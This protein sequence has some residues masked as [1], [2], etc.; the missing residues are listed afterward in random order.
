LL[1]F[2]LL[3]ARD[4]LLFRTAALF[5]LLCFY[6]PLA[7]LLSLT[8]LLLPG[9]VSLLNLFASLLSPVSLVLRRLL[10]HRYPFTRLSRHRSRRRPLLFGRL[11]LT[12]PFRLFL[13]FL[14]LLLAVITA[15]AAAPLCL[16]ICTQTDQAYTC[17][18]ERDAKI[19]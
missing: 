18:A 16:D 2:G 19:S 17:N 10:R 13:S 3:L 11:S 9:V 1:P 15:I 5:G 7:I 4:S 6:L 12:F 14:P 8:L